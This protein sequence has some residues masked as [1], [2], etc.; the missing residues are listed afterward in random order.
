[1][2]QETLSIF[3]GLAVIKL[4]LVFIALTVFLAG[5]SGNPVPPSKLEGPPPRLMLPP[6]KFP[7]LNAGDDAVQKLAEAAE[8]H[9][10]EARRMRG[11]QQYVRKV[12]GE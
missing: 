9:N 6:K 12:R 5:C 3:A 10:R 7:T 2:K 4:L 1:M 11:L 8:L